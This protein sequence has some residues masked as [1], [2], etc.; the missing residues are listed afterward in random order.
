VP[1]WLQIAAPVLLCVYYGLAFAK[2]GR[3]AKTGPVAPRYE[4]PDG[5]SP[6][7][8][9]YIWKHTVDARTVAAVFAQLATKSLITI[10]AQGSALQINRTSA[11]AEGLAPEENIAMDWLFA[12]IDQSMKFDPRADYE[13]CIMALRGSLDRYL[14]NRY[15]TGNIRYVVCGTLIFCL[16]SVAMVRAGTLSSHSLSCVLTTALLLAAPVLAEM[17]RATLIEPIVDTTCGFGS[18]DRLIL[19]IV[20]VGMIAIPIVALAA[21]VM[22]TSSTNFALCV[23]GM[24]VLNFA[25]VPLL[26]R[27]TQPGIKARQQIAGY[28]EFLIA[29]EQDA[30]DRLNIPRAA[31]DHA[32]PSLPYA[33]ALEVKEKW[34]DALANA[35]SPRLVT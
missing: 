13:G 12:G 35:F 28:R 25:A 34:G 15:S 9:R 5:L 33:I 3:A 19:G 30:L 11:R 8:V 22:E 1:A 31:L 2:L 26:R 16:I 27:T 23:V 17:V 32:V 6:A 29:V 20:V 4:P 7:A 14:R 10:E 18:I 21:K 24:G